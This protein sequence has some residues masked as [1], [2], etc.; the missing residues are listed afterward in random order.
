M[1]KNPTVAIEALLN[2]TTSPQFSELVH[3]TKNDILYIL[4]SRKYWR[5]LNLAVGAQNCYYM[6]IDKYKFGGS[7]W[8]HHMYNMQVGNFGGF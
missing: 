1:E 8:D 5:E 6:N 4:Y 3:L 2:L 7:A